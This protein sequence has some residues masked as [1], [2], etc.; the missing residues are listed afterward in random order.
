MTIYLDVVWALNFFLDMMLLM[1]TQAIAKEKTTVKRLV[2]GA[3]IASLLVP[4]TLYYPNSFSSTVIGKIAYSLLII[5][6]TFR[7]YS[8]KR[9][10]KLLFLFYFTTFSIGGGLIAVHYLFQRPIGISAEG[11]FTFQSGFGDPV[12]WTFVILGFPISWFFTKWRMDKHAIEKIRYDQLYSIDL[13]IKGETYSTTG[14]IDSGNQLVDP[15]TKKPVVI[16]D[17]PFLKNWFSVDDWTT[18]K[19]IYETLNI[20]N[21][22]SRWEDVIQLIPYQG[23][24]GKNS[25]M[26]AIK[27][28]HLVIHYHNHSI[29]TS[30]V[31]VGIQFAT[32]TGDQMYHC[33]LHP[34]I[35]KLAI[36]NSA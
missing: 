30:K 34:Q 19:S 10:L 16:C 31:L 28:D 5:G 11:L 8:V 15:L 23:V 14:Y 1:L 17:E 35:V 9:F 27:P 22:P 20:A 13:T 3:F 18:L 6:C 33:L 21:I 36:M 32:L 7:W 2:V 24:A 25:F 12:S 4:I 29:E 26:L